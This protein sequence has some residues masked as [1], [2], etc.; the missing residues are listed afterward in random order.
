MQPSHAS[1]RACAETE[2][3]MNKREVKRVSCCLWERLALDEEL[4]A[5][6]VQTDKSGRI[7]AAEAALQNY[8]AALAALNDWARR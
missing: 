6:I 4:L 1:A 5:K 2:G 3:E 8:S 7:R